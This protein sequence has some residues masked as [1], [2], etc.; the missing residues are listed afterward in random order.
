MDWQPFEA[1][2][3]GMAII[4][5]WENIVKFQGELPMGP[6]AAK[7]YA[8]AALVFI[9]ILGRGADPGLSQMRPA[10]PSQSGTLERIGILPIPSEAA[11]IPEWM[12]IGLSV[13]RPM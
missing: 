9:D 4:V 1:P 3:M 10:S 6:G 12:G 2:S 13:A 11:A 8:V 5:P 7:A